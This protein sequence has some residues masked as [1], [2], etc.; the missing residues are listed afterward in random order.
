MGRRSL[1]ELTLVDVDDAGGGGG[2]HPELLGAAGQRVGRRGL[3]DLGAQRLDVVL[4]DVELDLLLLHPVRGVGHLGVE[5]HRGDEGT[6][7][8]EDDE[9]EEGEG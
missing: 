2:H 9:G 6:G 5:E 1:S 4:G 3:L 8:H 7:Q